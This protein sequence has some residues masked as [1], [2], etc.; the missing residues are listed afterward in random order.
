MPMGGAA[1]GFTVAFGVSTLL[2]GPII[3]L[4][5]QT[6]AKQTVSED[7]PARHAEKQ[8]TTTMGGL[9]ILVGLM[10]PV[11][12]DVLTDSRHGAEWALLGLTLAY[13]LI[14]FLDDYLIA[15]RGK[16]LGLKARQKL[17]LQFAFAI[18]FV[19]WM[20]AQAV[21]GRTTTLSLGEWSAD[22]GDW[23]YVLGTLL[24]VGLSNAVNFTDGLDGLAGGVTALAALALAA[25][26]FA[27]SSLGWLPLFGGALAGGCAGF[28][29]FNVHP[30]Q[31]F[32]GDTGSLALGAALAGMALLGK[33]EIP[34]QMY[35][36]VPWA[37]MASVMIQVAVF[38]WRK[39]TRGIE[40][41]R[42]NRVFRRTPLHHHFEEIGWR[43]TKIV[44]RFWLAT[45]LA[46]AVALAVW[47]R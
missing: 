42:E 32:M 28:L 3:R 17:V 36:A 12:V 40:Y 15:T 30:A 26:V 2:G 37:E 41:A 29:W 43:E 35:V 24:I 44:G 33:A 31:V 21:P 1:A 18:G 45:G 14:G 34:L 6:G 47:G 46:I 39:R 4:L 20:R 9:L 11:L 23:Y 25:T 38:K 13:G 7:A 22:L 16:N 5:K 19:I 8:G 10:V 27:G